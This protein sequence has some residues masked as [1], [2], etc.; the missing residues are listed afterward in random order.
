MLAREYCDAVKKKNKPIVLSHHMLPG[1]KEGQARFF[2]SCLFLLCFV[3]SCIE[4]PCGRVRQDKMS[5]SDPESAIF[6]EDQEHEVN[7]KI[8]KAFCP[9]QQVADNPCLEYLKHIVMPYNV[10]AHCTCSRTT[11]DRIFLPFFFSNGALCLF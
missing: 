5:K 2:P 3:C 9:P 1:L 7:T 4:W 11:V 10:R 6:M 8:K